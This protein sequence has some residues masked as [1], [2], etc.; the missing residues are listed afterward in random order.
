[1]RI[2]VAGPGAVGLFFARRLSTANQVSLLHYDK[3]TSAKL[4]AEGFTV[5]EDGV[6][7]KC[8]LSCNTQVPEDIDHI[9]IAV[10]TYSLR[11]LMA[12]LDKSNPATILTVQN[13]LGNCEL[14]CAHFPIDKI[15][16]GILTYGIS[17][18]STDKVELRGI[19]ELEIGG[20]GL[21][22]K[23]GQLVSTYKAAG[24]FTEECTDVRRAIWLKVGIN[25]CINPIATILNITNGELLN[26]PDIAETWQQIASE[27]S[28]A[29]S[30]EGIDL[31]DREI[32][33]SATKVAMAT[34]ENYCSMLQDVRAGRK[35]ENDA[36]CG[37][38]AARVSRMGI[39]QSKCKEL[40]DRINQ[41][42]GAHI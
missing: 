23:C 15:Y 10:K 42:C 41:V 33:S 3:E 32:I 35:T 27:V 5:I 11:Q 30:V 31:T 37:Q 7:H 1:M 21:G 18:L 39:T 20:W 13:G 6:P 12:S 16:A 29:A 36:I 28:I 24:I 4:T 40:F 38:I 2:L 17:R 19:G 25:A 8:Y 9:L 34:S 14:L 22:E 26:R